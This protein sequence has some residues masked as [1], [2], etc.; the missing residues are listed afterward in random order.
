MLSIA[1]AVRYP[2]FNNV[3]FTYT[4]SHFTFYFPFKNFCR[5][6]AIPSGLF[7]PIE[8]KQTPFS[9]QYEPLQEQCPNN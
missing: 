4:E 5:L 7:V 8:G 6:V 1:D 9:D 3:Y 2:F